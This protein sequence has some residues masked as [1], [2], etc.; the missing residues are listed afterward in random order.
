M[1]TWVM[2][3]RARVLA[4]LVAGAVDLIRRW[5]WRDAVVSCRTW[6]ERPWNPSKAT[7]SFLDAL[8]A[9]RK[10]LWAQRITVMSSPGQDNAKI[11][12]ALL[13]TLAYAA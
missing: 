6:T 12:K 2:T 4:G 10:A 11:T 8:A 13:D 5:R 7:P 9:L 1:V 3:G